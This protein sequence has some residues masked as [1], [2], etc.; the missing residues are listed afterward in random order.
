MVIVKGQSLGSQN[1]LEVSREY[2]N[3]LMEGL[4]CDYIPSFPTTRQEV[5]RCSSRWHA[6]L[7]KR[8]L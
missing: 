3:I 4:K 5:I 1:L 2:G 7:Y 8:G 6:A